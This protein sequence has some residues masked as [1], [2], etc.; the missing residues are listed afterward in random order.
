MAH[1][2]VEALILEI[3]SLNI[4][5]H[6]AW[7]G[8]DVAGCVG[9]TAILQV[10]ARDPLR[11]KMKNVSSRVEGGTIR[12]EQVVLS[13]ALESAA[14]RTN[15]V[16]ARRQTVETK[17]RIVAAAGAME[18]RGFMAEEQPPNGPQIGKKRHGHTQS[19]C[20]IQ[21]GLLLEIQSKDTK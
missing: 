14:F 12:Q 6:I 2:Q 13:V 15:R 10:G 17:F 1:D 16:Q 7:R 3:Y 4:D 5:L 19:T 9:L 18:H 8:P 11:G 20:K 21:L